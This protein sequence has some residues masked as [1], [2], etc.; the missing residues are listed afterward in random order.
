MNLEIPR[1][2]SSV[3][4]Q[5]HFYKV[6]RPNL[7]DRWLA[8]RMNVTL[9]LS[10]MEYTRDG[11]VEDKAEQSLLTRWANQNIQVRIDGEDLVFSWPV[12]R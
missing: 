9:P 3:S 6:P 1:G 2:E 10:E 11:V 7:I 8:P 12:T 5:L 4:A